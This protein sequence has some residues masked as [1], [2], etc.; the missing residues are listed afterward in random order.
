LIAQIPLAIR[1]IERKR[2]NIFKMDGLGM[3]DCQTASSNKWLEYPSQFGVVKYL[4]I[5]H[6]CALGGDNSI[7][8]MSTIA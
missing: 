6:E 1:E 8:V 3:R 4:G 2:P 7:R 5:D